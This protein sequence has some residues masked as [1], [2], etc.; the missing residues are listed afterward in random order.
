M[1]TTCT[2]TA[3]PAP[4]A[5]TLNTWGDPTA[6]STDAVIVRVDPNGGRVTTVLA[7]PSAPVGRT[8]D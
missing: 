7:I 8:P 2:V 6:P 1:L 4:V 3:V 5:V